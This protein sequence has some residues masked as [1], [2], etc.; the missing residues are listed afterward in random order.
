MSC[1]GNWRLRPGARRRI[2]ESV[3]TG[4]S[5]KR[6]SGPLLRLVG[7]GQPVG[8]PRARGGLA[9][10]TCT[11]S[12]MTARGWPIQRSTLASAPGPSV[13]SPAGRSTGCSIRGSLPSGNAWAYTHNRSLRELLRER[14]IEHRA[15]RPYRPQTTGRSSAT[16]RRSRANA[17]MAGSA[18]A[19]TRAG[20]PCHTGSSTTT[21]AGTTARSAT[22][23]RSQGF[24]RSSGRTS[25]SARERAFLRG[26]HRRAPP[27][28]TR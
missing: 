3:K 19:Q 17:P 26:Q 6:A 8:A 1:E 5:Q 18:Q 9:G 2:V 20:P 25:S 27:R 22:V 23:P 14:A 7:D 4:T 16:S 13:A 28:A 12:S 24:T 21:G 15:I 10:T 11:R